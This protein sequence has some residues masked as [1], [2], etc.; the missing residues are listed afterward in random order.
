[1]YDLS[2]LHFPMSVVRFCSSSLYSNGIHYYRYNS[3]HSINRY[4]YFNLQR[5]AIRYHSSQSWRCNKLNNCY[6]N[7]LYF[8]QLIIRYRKYQTYWFI[9]W[10]VDE[11]LSFGNHVL[12]NQVLSTYKIQNSGLILNIWN[13]EHA[14]K[15]WSDV[16]NVTLSDNTLQN[17]KSFFADNIY[18]QS[19]SVY[20]QRCSTIKKW[21]NLEHAWRRRWCSNL[22]FIKPWTLWSTS[23]HKTRANRIILHYF[24][25]SHIQTKNVA[26]TF[27][28]NSFIW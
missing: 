18:L 4:Y 19:Q 8:I 22:G 13:S 3:A 10:Y 6:G 1:M 5:M 17:D 21:K 28:C 11:F 16:A 2:S 26:F 7:Y 25:F 15:L 23:S 27:Q 12:Y 9:Y 14:W 24:H 20:H